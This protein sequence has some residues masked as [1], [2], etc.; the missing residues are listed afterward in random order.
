VSKNIIA[1]AGH[2]ESGKDSAT[3]FVYGMSMLKAGIIEEFQIGEKGELFVP[4]SIKDEQPEEQ[5]FGEFKIDPYLDPDLAIYLATVIW[6]HARKIALADPLKEF[7]MDYLGLPANLLW[8]TNE[9]KETVTKYKRSQLPLLTS[10]DVYDLVMFSDMLTPGEKL[11]EE[12]FLTIREVLQ[13][14][15]TELFRKID[16]EYWLNKN[17]ELIKEDSSKL[18]IVPD[19]R[20]E[21]EIVGLQ[22]EGVIVIYLTRNI[23]GNKDGHSSEKDVDKLRGLADFCIDNDKLTIEETHEILE[24]FLVDKGI[25]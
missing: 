25:L 8:G 23:H 14:V 3:R 5:M 7:A 18:V 13:L 19:V 16:P 1:F 15:G 9:D 17:R 10:E 11:E 2:K 4:V 22:K 20:F 21:N 12:K 6:P 24:K